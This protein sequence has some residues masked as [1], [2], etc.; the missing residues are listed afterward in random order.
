[1]SAQSRSNNTDNQSLLLSRSRGRRS[2]GE[3]TVYPR[4]DGRWAAALYVDGKLR[5]FY[6]KMKSAILCLLRQGTRAS[7]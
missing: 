4:S 7:L 6:G 2:N 1:M 5:Y 3:G